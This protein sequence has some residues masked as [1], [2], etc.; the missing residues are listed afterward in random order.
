MK[1]SKQNAGSLAFLAMLIVALGF[2]LL[3]DDPLDEDKSLRALACE[4]AAEVAEDARTATQQR[5]VEV[6]AAARGASGDY[7]WAGQTQ[8]LTPPME[9]IHRRGFMERPSRVNSVET[10]GFLLGVVC[11]DHKYRYSSKEA[12]L[13]GD[14]WTP[15]VRRRRCL[16]AYAEN[17]M[18]YAV[19]D[20]PTEDY[21]FLVAAR[22]RG[23][24]YAGWA[25]IFTLERDEVRLQQPES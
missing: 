13:P 20:G 6:C 2:G 16:E 15:D 24:L 17:L 14:E 3:L 7:A 5:T 18:E 23:D 9:Y 11:A 10:T 19:L 1:L 8:A 22:L 12:R 25:H 21:F 4:A